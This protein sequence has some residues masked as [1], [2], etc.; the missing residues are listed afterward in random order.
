MRSVLLR[1]FG[2]IAVVAISFFA[3]MQILDYWFTA[4]D[5]NASVIHVVDA[6]YGLACRDF[7]PPSGQPS[8]VKVGNATALLVG[9]C[10]NAKTTCIFTVD[11]AQVSDP[12]SGCAKD[13]TATWRC[14]SDQNVHKFYLPA[15][16]HGKS[17]VL[18]CPA[19]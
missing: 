5:P 14:G 17:A 4:Q 2:G 3:T 6:T 12:A 16:A 11:A 1:V 13:F 15:E 8:L 10:D 9:A 18:S 7:V 19:L